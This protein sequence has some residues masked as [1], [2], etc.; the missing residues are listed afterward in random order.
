M[1]DAVSNHPLRIF[2]C[3]ASNDKPT[4]RELYRRLRVDG[5]EPWLDEEDIFPGQKWQIEIP[6]A[7]RKSDVVL[8]CLS[9]H[10]ISKA[11]YVQKEIKFALDVADEQPEGTIFLIPLR[12]EACEVPERLSDMQWVNLYDEDGYARLLRALHKRAAELTEFFPELAQISR[13]ESNASWTMILRPSE[14]EKKFIETYWIGYTPTEFNPDIGWYPDEKSIEADL[15][16]LAASPFGGIIT[17]G[18]QNTGA[19]IPEIAK[20][21]GIRHVIMGVYDPCN[22]REIELAIAANDFVDGYCVGHM[23]LHERRYN[24]SDVI[25]AISKV[26]IETKKPVTT[27]EILDNLLTSEQLIESVD[28]L[29]PDVHHYWHEGSS[30]EVAFDELSEILGRLNS[31]GN[32]VRKDKIVV[33]KMIS[34]P[35]AGAPGL[36]PENQADF[37]SRISNRLRNTVNNPARVYLSFFA[38]FD[39]SWKTPERRW[40]AGELST[41]LYDI[42]RVPKQS[43]EVFRRQR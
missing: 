27:T 21:V 3:H 23:G 11:G 5:F 19:R 35:S 29:F 41:G 28:W 33:L 43:I 32:K 31:P 24:Q 6:K 1:T 20:G 16:I 13:H 34:Y 37:F 38:A 25:K 8:V 7:V 39:N 12:L 18:S 9:Q 36:T 17:F 30:P 26:R 4:V 42:A 40:N 2:L 22:L 10:S 14:I 15:R